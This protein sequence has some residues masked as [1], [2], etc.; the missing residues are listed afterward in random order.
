MLRAAAATLVLLPLAAFAALAEPPHLLRQGGAAQLI[1]QGRPML[2]LA[3]E[4]SNSAASSREYLAPHWARLKAMHLN[5]VIAPVSWE[6]IEPREGAFDWRS[7]DGLIADARANGLHLVVLWFGAW[8]NSMSTYAPAWVKRD[9][10]RFPRAKSADGQSVDILSAFSAA[11]RTADARAFAALLARVRADDTQQDTVL[12][13][14]VEN[15]IGMLPSARDFSSAAERAFRAPV[16]AILIRTLEAGKTSGSPLQQLWHANGAKHSGDWTALFGSGD[17]AAEVFSAWYY[18][19]FVE[20]LVKAG[21]AAYA[22]PMYVNAAQNRS[23][24]RPGE[25][26]SGGPL[27]QVWEAWK[28]GA[29]SLDLLAPD[30]Y[31]ANFTDIAQRYRRADNPLFIPEANYA[32]R[33]E[34]PANAFYAFGKLDAL[35]V[36]P[37]SIDSVDDP[38]LNRLA[39]AYAV[40]EQLEPAILANRGTMKMAAFRPH[41]LEDAR[42]DESPVSETIGDYRFQVSFAEAK[43]T[44]GG[45][46]IQLGRDEYLVS[47]QG[48]IVTF[49]S[50]TDESAHVGIDSDWEGSFGSDGRWIPGRLLNG[51]QTHQGRHLRL[52]PDEFQIQRLKLYRYH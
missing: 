33:A 25:Y 36:A 30:I 16:P 50:A 39:H 1:V 46:I 38:P 7:V 44:G 24:K 34:V 23:G 5:T 31:F 4:L 43:S 10:E 47:G 19:E 18:A 26:P 35:C 45:L 11:T 52:A 14:Q 15:E 3:G 41:I 12:M 40:L 49:T 20:A 32:D 13:V 8:K 51:D 2:L 28:S 48:M 29:P 17:D 42:V 27:V 9:F 21:K 6:L 22:L 37:F